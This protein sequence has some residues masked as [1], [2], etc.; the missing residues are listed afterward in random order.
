MRQLV[1]LEAR[2][3]TGIATS[4]SGGVEEPAVR[5]TAGSPVARA[6]SMA[7]AR[8]CSRS[9]S[10]S[11]SAS[12]PSSSSPSAPP[13]TVDAGASLAADAAD[14][15]AS[16]SAPALG[17]LGSGPVLLVPDSSPLR[18][19]NSGPSAPCEGSHVS[20]SAPR[21]AEGSETGP[22]AGRAAA[23][24]A[25]AEAARMAV[26]VVTD[27]WCVR[28]EGTG[29]PSPL[30]LDAASGAG[31]AAA[32]A[33][34]AE[35][36]TSGADTPPGG[37]GASPRDSPRSGGGGGSGGKADA[38]GGAPAVPSEALAMERKTPALAELRR[39]IETLDPLSKVSSMDKASLWEHRHYAR[40]FARLLP[41]FL[42]SLNWADSE[43][44]R[45]AQQLVLR[46]QSFGEPVEA[47]ELLDEH[48][49]DPAVR[50]YAVKVL[51]DLP[52]RLVAKFLIQLTQALKYEASLDSPLARFLME[53]ALVQPLL[54]GVPLFWACM[55]E[56]KHVEFASRYQQFMR[57]YLTLCTD[58][59]RDLLLEQELMWAQD[60]VFAKIAGTVIANK[61]QGKKVLKETLHRELAK[62]NAD[63]D[64][65]LRLPL[66]PRVEVGKL[67]VE[68]CKVMSSAKLPLWLVFENADPNAPPV[69][70]MFKAGD[71][72]RQDA[73]T[74]QLI[75][76]MDEMWRSAALDLC[77][78]PY[79]CLATWHDGGLLEIVTNSVTTAEIHKRYG[80][81]L[82]AYKK[83]TFVDWIRDNNADEE[84]FSKAVDVFLRSAAGYCVATYVMG[85][86]D[87]HNDNIMVKKSGQY[88]HID[89]GHF[90]GNF[91]Y[92]FGIKRERTAMVFTPE[93]AHVMGGRGAPLFKEFEQL[94]GRAFNV[95][96][97]QGSTL[98]NMFSLMVP[99]RM[100]ELTDRED[101]NYLRDMLVL[102]L[103]EVEAAK[104]FRDQILVAL[105]SR[106]K[107]FDN[108]IHILKHG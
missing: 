45:E 65:T 5:G 79:K 89:F 20:P 13:S 88:F 91:K 98:I 63:L 52:D 75:T 37:G 33:T 42:Q 56:L 97:K 58:A 64:I 47:L 35:A 51:R 94:C 96:R 36:K 93:M 41:K 34:A 92:Q 12:P 43:Q 48:F 72:L 38:A 11:A 22:F 62:L 7:C 49:A 59:Q 103:S 16:P 23:L 104:L 24:L 4:E 57:A 10:G 73:V 107:R 27:R 9:N 90:L 21:S 25:L 95:L 50:T 40:H 6:S 71:D 101:I 68:K 29:S 1:T 55:V 44:A 15:A 8:A 2:R 77:L 74:L 14:A 69:L 78:T 17:M 102:N 61:K 60:G 32:A 76:M 53:R 85:I 105:S 81:K 46:W 87:R 28:G 66:D 108:T 86:G 30:P 3:R 67:I 99:A 100:P 80:G 19:S 84:N 54:I 26:P 82:G 70:V 39:R 31:A 106:F 83:S 18:S